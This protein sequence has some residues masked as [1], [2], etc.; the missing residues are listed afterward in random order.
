M[1]DFDEKG[2]GKRIDGVII[3]EVSHFTLDGSN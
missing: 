2:K 1:T 3:I